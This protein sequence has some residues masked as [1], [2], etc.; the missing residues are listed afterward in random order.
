MP[1][2]KVTRV[3]TESGAGGIISHRGRH[4]TH[5]EAIQEFRAYYVHQF[6]RA[7]RALRELERGEIRVFHERG[8][9][10]VRDSREVP[11]DA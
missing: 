6:D 4:A 5:E 11:A 2:E 9:Y 1:A 10:S 8:I 7:Q 3:R